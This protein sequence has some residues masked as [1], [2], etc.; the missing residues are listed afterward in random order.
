MIFL[1]QINVGI[2]KMSVSCLSYTKILDEQA[3]KF[4]S[5]ITSHFLEIFTISSVQFLMFKT[6]GLK[7]PKRF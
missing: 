7:I 4:Y 5:Y 1:L 2:R 3:T 6:L